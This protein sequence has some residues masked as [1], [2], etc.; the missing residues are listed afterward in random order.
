MTFLQGNKT[1]I[2]GIVMILMVVVEKFMGID[3]PGIEV[4]DDYLYM[5]LAALG[6]ITLRSGVSAV[7]K[8]VNEVTDL[9]EYDVLDS[10]NIV[11][12][13]INRQKS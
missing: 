2:V 11:L 7:E 5:A 9:V 10:Q 8:K 13:E 12:N 6:L 3:I 1:Y 4:T